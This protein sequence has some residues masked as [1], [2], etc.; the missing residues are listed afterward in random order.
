MSQP[1][2]HPPQTPKDPGALA[3]L[4]A[5]LKRENVDPAFTVE[6]DFDK[7]NSMVTIYDALKGTTN[8]SFKFKI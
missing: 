8:V 7:N 6:H 5:D 4:N 3:D 1:V 2:D